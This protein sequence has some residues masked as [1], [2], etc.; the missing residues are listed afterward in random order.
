M[1]NGGAHAANNLDI[2][3]Y[4][5]APVGAK[6]FSQAIRWCSEIFFNL[7]ELLKSNS[8]S[9]SVGDEGGFAPNFKSNFEPLEFLIKAIKKSKLSPERDVMISLD[10]AS[11]EFYKKNKYYLGSPKKNFSSDKMVYILLIL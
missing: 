10:V 1:I 6:T 7:K 8:Y 2:Q 3:E 5:L 9:T 11:S 4:M